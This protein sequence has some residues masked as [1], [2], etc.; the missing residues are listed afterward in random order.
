MREEGGGTLT[1]IESCSNNSIKIAKRDGR[2]RCTAASASPIKGTL[3]LLK[4]KPPSHAL[5]G[6]LS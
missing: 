2:W 4:S 5:R 3:L 1:L 6:A